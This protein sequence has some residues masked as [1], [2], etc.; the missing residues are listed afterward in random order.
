MF[1]NVMRAWEEEYESSLGEDEGNVN[2][3]SEQSLL[4]GKERERRKKSLCIVERKRSFN[5]V[6]GEIFI[7]CFCAE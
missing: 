7:I 3:V 4:K 5:Q 2:Y 6:K 1:L